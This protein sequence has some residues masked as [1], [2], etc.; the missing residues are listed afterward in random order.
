MNTT[1]SEFEQI[2]E[3]THIEEEYDVVDNNPQTPSE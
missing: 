1:T 2:V 3:D